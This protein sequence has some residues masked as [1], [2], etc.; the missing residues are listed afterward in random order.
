M[1]T[2]M[3]LTALAALAIS[4]NAIAL[5]TT[6]AGSARDIKVGDDNAGQLVLVPT[7]TINLSPSAE[8]PYGACRYNATWNFPS[9]A[10]PVTTAFCQLIEAKRPG[11]LSCSNNRQVDFATFVKD[12][13][14]CEGVD[15]SGYISTVRLALTESA[16]GGLAGACTFDGLNA[17]YCSFGQ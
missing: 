6:P 10:V 17:D 7:A 12:G 15:P 5:D 4:G 9:A 13:A 8:T 2:A 14:Y 11:Y 3:I 16:G 1:K